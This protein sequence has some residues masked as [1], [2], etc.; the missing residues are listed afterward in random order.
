MAR[1]D[2]AADD[3]PGEGPPAA[4][5][6][7]GGRFE[8]GPAEAVRRFTSSIATDIVLYRYDI[9]GS[10]AHARMLAAQGIIP[11]AD[12]DAILRGL[13][14]VESEI[15]A[16]ELELNDAREDIHTH[17]EAR[18][19]EIIGDDAAGRLHTGRSRN[20]QV[21]LDTR[22]YTREAVNAAVEGIRA[23]QTALVGLAERH[24]TVYLPGYTH[25]QRAQP[26]LLAH[27]LLAYFE[28]LERDAGR[29]ADVR[30]RADVM[31]LGSAALAGA[32]YPLD[33]EAVAKE[34]GFGAISAN[35]VDAVSDRDYIV[36]YLSAAAIALVHTSRLS[37]ELVLWSSA[38][39]GYLHFDDAHATGSSIMP[40]KKNPDVA[41]L[42]RAKSG[43]VIGHLVALL[44]T[45]KG[46]PLAYN[47]DLQ[48]DKPG[49]FDTAETLDR[50]LHVLAA[51]LEGACIDGARA[52]A[53]VDEDP[54]ILATDYA[55]YLAR[56]GLPFRAAHA[57]VGG[58]VR[59]CEAE[60]KG[61]TG[62]S[63]AEL[64]EAQPLFEADA[65]AM[66][67]EQ[68]LAARD[69]PGGTAPVRVEQA[70]AEARQRLDAARAGA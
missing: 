33:R 70:L 55:D 66:T 9:A 36:E 53:A 58:L 25:L 14:Q 65:V 30:A 28:M 13:D 49:L 34:L 27:H 1:P 63:L 11:A 37:E 18:L 41:E 39:F 56:K 48:D 15:A 69:L 26:L 57:V 45:L 68:A 62:L 51:A 4:R 7:W 44:T 35:S 67:V 8:R 61:L 52:Q 17:V 46:L 16:G 2:D 50:T 54:F 23:L 22:L 29:F 60:G 5:R 20:D 38:E 42:A 64:Q 24:R 43:R 59:R 19:A 31:P 40:Q 10:R 21:A 12:G 47:R 6:T 3:S 32:A